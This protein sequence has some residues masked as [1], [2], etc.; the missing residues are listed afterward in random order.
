MACFKE[1]GK[2][3][4]LG[5]ALFQIAATI[6]YSKR[7]NENYCFPK[8]EY[9][10]CFNFDQSNFLNHTPRYD[11]VY[12]EDKYTYSNIPYKPNCNL[13]GYFQ[14]KKYFED[15]EG[16]IKN[17]LTPKEKKESGL[18]GDVC[19]IH[20]RRGDY[21]QFKDFHT[22]LQ[23]D[24]YRKAMSC[25]PVSKF[26]IISD[27]PEW[28]KIAFAYDERCTVKKQGSVMDD[29]TTLSACG[30][31]IIANSSFSWWAAYLNPNQNKTVVA[32]KEWFGPKLKDI[33]PISD[34]IPSEWRLV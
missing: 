23:V 21:I 18:Y 2:Y 9:Q 20:I 33:N 3:G 28:C 26:L 31:N 34:L 4:R 22:V 5:N 14:S 29:F 10:D 24:Y 30:H 19:G 12:N 15:Q 7:Y 32:P 25:I 6:A 13:H 8:W 17:I 1:L 27:D 11:N 16:Y